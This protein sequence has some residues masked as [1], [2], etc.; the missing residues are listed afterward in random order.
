ML[1]G[2]ALAREARDFLIGLLKLA[3]PST[4]PR[5]VLVIGFGRMLR[6]NQPSPKESQIMAIG[7]LGDRAELI[8]HPKTADGSVGEIEGEPTFELGDPSVAEIRPDPVTGKPFAHLIGQ[9]STT[10]TVRVDADPTAGVR[11]LVGVGLLVCNDPSDDAQSV[12][13]EFGPFEPAPDEPA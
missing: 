4:A 13:L 2:T 9:G 10:V 8:A 7:N 5:Q 6:P 12:E 3:E 1:T 11:E